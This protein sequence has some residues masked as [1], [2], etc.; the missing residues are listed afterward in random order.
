MLVSLAFKYVNRCCLFTILNLHS[1]ACAVNFR[2]DPHKCVFVVRNS[3]I[4]SHPN[5]P[6]D[7]FSTD[8]KTFQIELYVVTKVFNSM[9][10]LKTH[11]PA[12]SSVIDAFSTVHTNTIRMRFRFDPL[13]RLVFKS[14][15]F[16]SKPSA[17]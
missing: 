12:I 7:A 14:V 4:D 8:T 3:S 5:Y 10:M 11:A 9:R 16:R 6:F 17:S 2:P 13:S 1:C 15:C